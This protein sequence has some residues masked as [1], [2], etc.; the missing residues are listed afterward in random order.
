MASFK[1]RFLIFL[2]VLGLTAALGVGLFAYI[3]S[4]TSFSLPQGK[5]VFDKLRPPS[6]T[7][8]LDRAGHVL[9]YRGSPGRIQIYKPTGQIAEHLRRFIV[10][11]EDAKFFDHEGFD[12]EEIKNSVEKNIERGKV[13]RGASTITQQLAKNLFLS[14]ERS[15]ERKLFEIPWTMRIELDLTKAQILELYLN[16]IE[17]GPGLFGAEAAARHFFDKTAAQLTV[18]Q[19]LY[20]AMIV[21]N[22]VRFDLFAH[23]KAR[24]FIER[25]RES[26]VDRLLA[27]KHIDSSSTAF[28]RADPFG[29]V[30]PDSPDR[31]FAAMHSG[32]YFG[33][34][35]RLDQ[36]RT[37]L[38]AEASKRSAQKC[39]LDLSW[40]IRL[41][42]EALINGE[43]E[44]GLN[45]MAVTEGDQI[46]ALR[47]LSNGKVPTEDFREAVDDAGFEIKYLPKAP[48]AEIFATR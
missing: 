12:F 31:S 36:S 39:S 38:I 17:W 10:L 3:R 35:S 27:E 14:K 9:A 41:E 30:D 33:G 2:G 40:Q 20:L 32:P 47:K 42:K 11:S 45:W 16:V 4:Q 43:R 6:S 5:L 7:A 21:P 13:K 23:P 19:S 18:G 46:L 8:I 15:I 22:P 24:D 44:A 25:K 48:W 28:Y 37:E 34:Q 26:F 29:L 1:R